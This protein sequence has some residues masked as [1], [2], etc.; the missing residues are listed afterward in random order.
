MHEWC[1]C[2]LRVFYK[3]TGSTLIEMKEKTEK[4][5]ELVDL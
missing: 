2:V 4:V 5:K 3:L 1:E